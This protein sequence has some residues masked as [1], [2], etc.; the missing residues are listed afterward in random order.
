MINWKLR[1]QNKTTLIA[2]LSAVFLMVEQFG[3]V[4]PANI[5]EGVNTFILILTILGVVT[6]PT[7]EGLGDSKKALTYESPKKNH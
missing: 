7:T 6:D 1:L 2:L 3:L 5:R 4:I